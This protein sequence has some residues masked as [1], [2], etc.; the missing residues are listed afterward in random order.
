LDRILFPVF[1]EENWEFFFSLHSFNQEDQ[2]SPHT[3]HKLPSSPLLQSPNKD[4]IRERIK[5][6]PLLG[7]DTT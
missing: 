6:L 2:T 5:F 4:Q 1:G 7:H 3:H